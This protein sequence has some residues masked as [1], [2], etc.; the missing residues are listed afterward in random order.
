VGKCLHVLPRP[1]DAY[2]T[3]AGRAAKV[4]AIYLHVRMRVM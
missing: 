2:P 4:T 1:D 3:D